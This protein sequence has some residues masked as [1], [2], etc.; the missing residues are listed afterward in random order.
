MIPV[1]D[2]HM[3][4]NNSTTGAT[5]GAVSAY[6]SGGIHFTPDCYGDGSRLLYNEGS[7]TSTFMNV[8]NIP[9]A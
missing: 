9:K 5:S 8:L 2:K 3:A 6:L 4:F 1:A 7:V